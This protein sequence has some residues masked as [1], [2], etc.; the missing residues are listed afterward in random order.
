MTAL[1]SVA[2]ARSDGRRR[3]WLLG[4]LVLFLAGAAFMLPFVAADSPF[5]VALASQALIAA[6]LALSLDLL[7]GN[8][9]L[10]SFGHAGW[11][12]FGAYVAGLAAKHVSPEL[13]LLLPFTVVV[14]VIFAT[15]IGSVLTR[16]IGKTFAILT[17]ALGQIFYSLVFVAS[18]WTGGEDGL[19]GIP[20]ATLLGLSI[21]SPQ[22]WYWLLLVVLLCALALALYLRQ[23]P[24]GKGWLAIK[25]N[26]ERAQFIG[27][28]TVN[29]KLLAYVLSAALA[30]I[31]GALFVMFVGATSPETLT[32]FESGKILMYV[33]LGG[34]GTLIGPIIGAGVFTFAE[35]YVSNMTSAWLIYFG[36]LFV[37]IVIVAPGGL[38]GLLLKLC[39]R[40]S[41]GD[42]E[43][44]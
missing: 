41:G 30:A 25:D 40:L 11:Y 38:F 2:P 35:H 1:G 6:I 21:A 43:R 14:T 13:L 23:T 28:D 3:Q 39:K 10:L 19:Q 31:A 27:I 37:L 42:G 12:G 15:A 9:G 8:T 18:K 7:M 20:M 5:I 22:A 36:G 32:W 29:L 17:L 16:Q 34:V 24:L 44:P 33:V 4:A 26:T